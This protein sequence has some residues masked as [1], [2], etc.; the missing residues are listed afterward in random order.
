MNIDDLISSSSLGS[1]GARHLINRTGPEDAHRALHDSTGEHNTPRDEQ[2]EASAL[3]RLLVTRT[4][5]SWGA[6]SL[7]SLGLTG[8]G[9]SQSEARIT[10]LHPRSRAE[11]A[12]MGDRVGD[13]E[14]ILLNLTDV[15]DAEVTRIVDF[16]AGVAYAKNATIERVAMRF[17][18]VAPSDMIDRTNAV[19][20]HLL[21]PLEAGDPQMLTDREVEVLECVAR[22]MAAQQIADSTGVSINTVRQLLVRVKT[23]YETSKDRSLPSFAE[24]ARTVARSGDI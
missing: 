5:P 11:L 24:W 4:I 16:L 7:P 14:P 22:G 18:L 10:T 6:L 21:D 8:I 3:G 12:S 1:K 13:G 19:R 2:A 20:L 17:F 15:S 9:Q 23:R